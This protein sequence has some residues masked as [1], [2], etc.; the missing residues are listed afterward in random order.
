MERVKEKRLMIDSYYRVTV[1]G[2]HLTFHG[3]R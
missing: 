2:G 3:R 1:G